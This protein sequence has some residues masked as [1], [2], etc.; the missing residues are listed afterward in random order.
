MANY[1]YVDIKSEKMNQD[2][3]NEIFNEISSKNKIRRFNFSEGY[4]SYNSRGLT[5]ITDILNKYNF[6]DEEDEISIKDE[7]ELV[8]ETI[9]KGI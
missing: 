5:D 4:L 7:F 3:A 2:I 1:Y 6:N 8:Y 9:E